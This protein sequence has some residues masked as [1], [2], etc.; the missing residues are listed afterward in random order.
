MILYTKHMYLTE[1]HL[2]YELTIPENVIHN[3]LL[4][5]KEEGLVRWLSG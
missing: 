3:S 4:N 5:W 2:N 1:F